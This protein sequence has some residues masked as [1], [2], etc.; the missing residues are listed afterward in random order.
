MQRLGQHFLLLLNLA[1]VRLARIFP[2]H[3]RIDHDG[4]SNDLNECLHLLRQIGRLGQ[5]IIKHFLVIE[6]G[7]PRRYNQRLDLLNNAVVVVLAELVPHETITPQKRLEPVPNDTAQSRASNFDEPVRVYSFSWHDC[8][9]GDPSVGE[10]EIVMFT[11]PPTGSLWP[12]HA[13]CNASLG[14]GCLK[15][16][17][18]SRLMQDWSHLVIYG[19]AH[20]RTTP[21]SISH[22]GRTGR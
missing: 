16:E 17:Q 12:I 19:N 7:R 9:Y 2:S 4:A 22:S 14:F 3:A 20:R 6:G 18:D 13:H 8:V 1:G 10:G 15:A 21:L 5:T 11:F